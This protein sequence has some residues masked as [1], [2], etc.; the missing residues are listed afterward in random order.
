MTLKIFVNLTMTLKIFINL[1]TPSVLT[2]YSGNI[3][4]CPPY[5]LLNLFV[6]K[7]RKP[8]IYFK[9]ICMLGLSG[10]NCPFSWKRIYV[11][12]AILKFKLE[13]NTVMLLFY[14]YSLLFLLIPQSKKIG[15]CRSVFSWMDNLFQITQA[16]NVIRLIK[17]F[18][19]IVRLTKIFKVIYHLTKV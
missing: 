6:S 17:I 19:V 11:Y 13:P 8:L 10:I 18:K 4:K 2:L 7:I 1:I 5:I 12:N 15:Q 9:M 16:F 3:L 14:I